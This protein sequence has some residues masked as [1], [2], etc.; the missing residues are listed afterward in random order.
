MT[1]AGIPSRLYLEACEFPIQCFTVSGMVPNV[2]D[3][4]LS[5]GQGLT[6][7]SAYANIGMYRELKK[8][9]GSPIP[10]PKSI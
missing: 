2:S 1:G 9:T 3:R 7:P 8:L 10:V 5:F 6:P 4:H